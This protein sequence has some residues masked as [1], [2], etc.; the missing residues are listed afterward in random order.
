MTRN[1]L[2]STVRVAGSR[3]TFSP[4]NWRRTGTGLV[5]VRAGA[6]SVA[7]YAAAGVVSIC[8][9]YPFHKDMHQRANAKVLADAGALCIAGGDI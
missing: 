4:S 3:P 9:P 7:E 6:V 5:R 1:A 8:M 2:G